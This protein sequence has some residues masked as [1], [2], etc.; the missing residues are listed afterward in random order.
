[1]PTPTAPFSVCTMPPTMMPPV[2]ARPL[3]RP[4]VS[5]LAST[6]SMSMPGTATMPNSRIKKSQRFSA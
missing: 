5:A 6:N 2:A 3:S 1:M 4:P